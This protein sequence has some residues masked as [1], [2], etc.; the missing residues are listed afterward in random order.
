MTDKM[1]VS[2][3]Q[4]LLASSTASLLSLGLPNE[5]AAQSNDDC[6]FCKFVAGKGKFVKLWEDKNFLAFLDYRPITEGHTLLVPKK[7]FEYLFD[8]DDK[9]YGKIFKRAKQLSKPLKTAMQSK[10][11]GVIVEGFGVNHVH[12]HLVPLK[13]GGEL[14]KKGVVGVTDEE[15]AKTAEKIIGEIAKMQSW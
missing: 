10:R 2:R 6:I 15:F 5:V 7:H 14:L 1:K 12:I 13:T 3:R 9:L 11:I 8:L 4:F